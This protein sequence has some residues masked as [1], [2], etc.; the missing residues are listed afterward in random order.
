MQEVEKVENDEK[1]VGQVVITHLDANDETVQI[2]D[3]WLLHIAKCLK[4]V[5]LM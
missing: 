1:V 2:D 4:K 5:V 3:K